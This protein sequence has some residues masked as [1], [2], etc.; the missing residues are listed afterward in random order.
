MKNRI[1]ALIIIIAT[2]IG[3]FQIAFIYNA[4]YSNPMKTLMFVLALFGI[5]ISLIIASQEEKSAK[6]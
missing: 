4:D 6:N 1:I 5:L 3:T 2:L